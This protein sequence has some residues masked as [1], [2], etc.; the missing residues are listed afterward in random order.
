MK[1]QIHC[2][3]YI[4]NTYEVE[5]ESKA[6]ALNN[7]NLLHYNFIQN[8]APLNIMETMSKEVVS[9]KSKKRPKTTELLSRILE[10]DRLGHKTFGKHW[11]SE[12]SLDYGKSEGSKRI[13]Y[14][15]FEPAGA[16]YISDV[17]K[18]IFTCFEIKSCKEDVYS[19]N[20]LN[21]EG[22][23]NYIVTTM[24]CY[25][26]LLDDIRDGTLRKHIEEYNGRTVHYGIMVAV[27]Y[28]RQSYD[29]FENPTPFDETHDWHLEIVNPCIPSHRTRSTTELLFCMLRSKQ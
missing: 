6:L 15:L 10:M 26:S 3:N 17:E 14:V 18:G 2:S 27:P 22:E 7:V 24:E 5:A 13:D 21:F 8:I 20:G 12:A 1:Y 4:E 23:K 25:K 29:E 9:K 16:T 28:G 11:A 19:G